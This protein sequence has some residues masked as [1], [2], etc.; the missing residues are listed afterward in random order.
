MLIKWTG[1]SCHLIIDG[2]R[3][4]QSTLIDQEPAKIKPAFIAFLPKWTCLLAAR[5]RERATNVDK[6]VVSTI[7]EGDR[8]HQ[9]TLIDKEPA[10]R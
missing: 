7:S 10:T 3:I 6:L 8:I 2:D 4:H 9:S 1:E 5:E